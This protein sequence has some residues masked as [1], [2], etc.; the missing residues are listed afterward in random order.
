MARGTLRI[1]L[2]AAPGV[3][4]TFDMLNEG[5]RRHQRGTDV[6]VGFVETHGRVNTLAQ[7]RDL[8]VV[9]RRRLV[10]RGS[11]FEEMDLDAVLARNPEVALVD[12]LA[13]T[14]VPGSRNAKRWQDV[15]V[16]LDAGI[17]VISTVNVQHLESLNDV[18]QGITGIEQRETIPDAVV[19]SADQVELVDMTP[20]ALRR[21]MAHG[22]IY[23]PERVDA[24]L[25]NYFRTGNLGALRELA[26]M[27][28]ADQVDEALERYRAEQGILKPWETRERVVVAITGA[29]SGD[30]VI[31]RAGRMA[32]RTRGELHGVHVRSSDGLRAP[33]AEGLQRQRELLDELSGVY[34][35][36][37]G[38]DVAEALVRF[39]SSENATQLVLGESRRS[40]WS[41]VARGSVINRV[42]RKSGT[43][44]VHVISTPSVHDTSVTP[45]IASRRGNIRGLSV[46]RRTTGWFVAATVPIV[47]T[48]LLTSLRDEIKLPGD[49]LL[50]VLLVVTVATIGG[51]APAVLASLESVLLANWY[52]APPVHTFTIN[53]TEDQI[54]FVVFLVVSVTVG[55]LVSRS[56]RRTA[57]AVQARAQAETL[58]ALSGTLASADDP[59]VPLVAQLRSAFGAEAVSVLRNDGDGWQIE[60]S[61]GDDP[62]KEPKA[63]AMNL[64][65]DEQSMLVMTGS[66]LEDQDLAVLTAFTGHLALAVERRRLQSEAASAVA[67]A[68][69]NELRTA[70]LAAVSHDLRTPL[71][72]I[73]AAVTSL[74]QTDVA[75]T[76]EAKSELLATI[77]E[78]ADR[79]NRLVGNLLDM[80]RLQTGAF[81]LLLRD[82][83][84]EEVVHAAIAG[85]D[86]GD[87]LD[88]DVPEVL[89]HIHTDAALLERVIANLVENALAWSSPESPV[90][91]EAAAVGDDVHLRVIDRGPGIPSAQRERIFLPFQRLGDR[92]NGTG[93]G[94]GLAVA[95]GF[96]EAIGGELSVEDTPGGGLTMVVALPAPR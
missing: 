65:L 9:P 82:V 80:S 85:L 16:L 36:V 55:V 24:A 81:Q 63:S 40:R 12:E 19:R 35:E 91:V 32:R 2:G 61:A 11:E 50:Y 10:H 45:R 77:D 28:V 73:K 42:I 23:P 7:I 83:G 90:R 53:D 75:W 64:S 21:R 37:A 3:G 68:E 34:H 49:L 87:H 70:L 57:E 17:D 59:L 43:I 67:L 89:P 22:N 48:L 56:A 20:E 33:P 15:E 86:H 25:G 88:V 26:L 69:A 31:R 62:P 5:W 52:F 96:V 46:R 1:Y 94:L 38:D 47:L 71:S 13:H 72:S 79:L 14:N 44:D 30:A 66:E 8:E 41:E 78:E 51:I 39:A 6:V 58:A 93:V 4:K 92:S 74:L 27:W 84:L 76:P 60:A 29:P 95:K 54:A 18:V